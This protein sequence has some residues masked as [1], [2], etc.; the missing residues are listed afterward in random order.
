MT[1]TV[2]QH[3]ALKR[4][5]D[6]AASRDGKWLAVSVQRLDLDGAKYVSDLW[7]VPTNGGPAGELPRRA[8]AASRRG[9]GIHGCTKPRISRTR[10]SSPA[11][12]P[13]RTAST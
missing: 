6:I 1:Y 13:A 12:H 3:I 10:T 5:S 8:T 7:K 4:V 9:T 2:Q 11:M